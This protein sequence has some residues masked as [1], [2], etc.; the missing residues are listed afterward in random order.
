[1]AAPLDGQVAHEAEE[2]AAE[3]LS[4]CHDDATDGGEGLGG[5]GGALQPGGGGG[6]D[7]STVRLRSLTIT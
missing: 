3:H 4:R 2:D 7:G 6:N 5:G 1:M